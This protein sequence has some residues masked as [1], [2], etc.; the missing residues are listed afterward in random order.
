[1]Y[2]NAVARANVLGYSFDVADIEFSDR[3]S[4]TTLYH[5]VYFK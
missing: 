2:T 4:G 5:R 3:T 1:M